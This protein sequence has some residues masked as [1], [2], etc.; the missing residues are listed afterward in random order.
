MF[1]RYS[2]KILRVVNRKRA[3]DFLKTNTDN[4]IVIIYGFIDFFF[5]YIILHL[6]R[7]EFQNYQS[8]PLSLSGSFRLRPA[9]KLIFKTQRA[10]KL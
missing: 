8:L 7:V 5:I 3:V 10:L 9:D 2:F 4:A 6:L 1:G